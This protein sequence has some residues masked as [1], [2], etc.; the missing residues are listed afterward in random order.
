MNAT[1]VKRWI[2]LLVLTATVSGCAFTTARVDLAYRP[3]AAQKI[4]LS[5]MQP[6]VLAVQVEDQRAPSE[7]DRV[8]N[9]RNSFG[10]ITASVQANQKEQWMAG[11]WGGEDF[12]GRHRWAV[13]PTRRWS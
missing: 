9:K 13:C 10:H 7:Q 5:T 3:E 2:M 1:T 11:L 6:L 8:G 4:P 12:D